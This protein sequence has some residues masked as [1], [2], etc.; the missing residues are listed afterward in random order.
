ML[1]HI[2]RGGEGDACGAQESEA[3]ADAKHGTA[4]WQRRPCSLAVP[5]WRLDAEGRRQRGR[6]D[7]KR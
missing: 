3:A 5:W 1:R 4:G 6:E 7:G 2:R